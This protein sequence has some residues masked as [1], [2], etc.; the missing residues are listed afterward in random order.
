MDNTY[1]GSYKISADILSFEKG[2]EHY[3]NVRAIRLDS[4]GY[5]LRIMSDYLPMIG[6][7]RGNMTIMFADSEVVYENITGFYRHAHNNFEFIIKDKLNVR[8]NSV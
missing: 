5:S 7:L 3:D 1:S 4:D 2:T 6:E 8:T